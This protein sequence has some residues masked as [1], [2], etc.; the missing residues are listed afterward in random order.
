M[1]KDITRK[2]RNH[3]SQPVN[4][5]CA[6]VYLLAEVRKILERDKLDPKPFALWQLR[7]PRQRLSSNRYTRRSAIRIRS[8]SG[9]PVAERLPF[10]GVI[11]DAT[12]RE[13]GT[14]RRGTVQK[15]KSAP[16]KCSRFCSCP[17]PPTSTSFLKSQQPRRICLKPKH[18]KTGGFGKRPE[19][20][21][22]AGGREFESRRPTQCR[23]RSLRLAGPRLHTP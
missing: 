11:R 6:V 17:K 13:P 1:N 7:P 4:T 19:S 22:G 9:A 14:I 23:Q 18:Q 2:L 3:L 5:E 21:L 16:T 20:A 15:R 10:P 12:R 8:R